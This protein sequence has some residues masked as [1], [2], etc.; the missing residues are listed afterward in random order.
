MKAVIIIGTGPSLGYALAE[1]FGRQGFHVAMLA[2][3][4][5]NLNDFQEKLQAE[6]IS[7]SK[8]PIDIADFTAM[9]L[10]LSDIARQYPVEVLIYNAVVKQL[11]P[12]LELDVEIMV[13]NYRVDVAGALHAVQIIL[14]FMQEQESGTILFT[15]GGAALTPWTEAPTI[16]IAKAGIRSLA[17]MLSEQLENTSIKVGTVTIHGSIRPNTAF[18]PERIAEAYHQFYKNA[19]KG[20]ELT[21]KG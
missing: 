5:H 8:H 9:R 3:S 13:K 15:G 7:S 6:G 1:T 16:T 17:F 11:I 14:P 12:P 10:T 18:A 4:E 19:T 2:R 21:Y 20:I